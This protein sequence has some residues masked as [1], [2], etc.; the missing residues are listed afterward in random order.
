[1]PTNNS[2]RAV[3][4]NPLFTLLLIVSAGFVLT[5]L[6]YTASPAIADR[7]DSG[8]GS[9]A[10]ARW[11]DRRGPLALGIEIAAMIVVGTLAMA[12]DRWFTERASRE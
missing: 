7:P 12:T 4:A 1:M 6:A 8:P 5:A 9:I 2:R 10:L 11:L 3:T